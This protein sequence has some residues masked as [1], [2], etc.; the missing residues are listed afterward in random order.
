MM[1]TVETKKKV[2]A[3]EIIFK[4][5]KNKVGR[6]I[7]LVLVVA[8]TLGIVLLCNYNF[9]HQLNTTYLIGRLKESS[10]LTAAKLNFTGMS[11]F[12]D[13]GISFI[14][15][16]DFIMVFEATARIGIDLK[17][18]QVEADKINRVVWITLPKAEVLDVKVDMD[19][20]KYFDEK[21]AL[22][23]LD[24][25]E[26][27]NKA[28]A[29]A[30]EKAKEELSNMGIWEMADAHAED[31]IKDLIQDLVPKKYEIKIKR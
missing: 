10:E 27:A 31:L 23:N 28:N 16:S 21:F 12:K 13:S 14:N 22:F 18:V 9:G 26:D 19:K 24:G 30:E 20:I 1:E 5:L 8:I 3:M 29:L 6:I 2:N 4:I 11:E 7:S 17:Y 15:K 25:K